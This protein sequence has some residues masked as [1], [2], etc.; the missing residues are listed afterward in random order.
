VL[1]RTRREFV[2]P[3]D[4][5]SVRPLVRV[6]I[7]GIPLV[8]LLGLDMPGR[9]D[10]ALA[11]L[12]AALTVRALFLWLRPYTDRAMHVPA[13]RRRAEG[14]VREHGSDSLAY[15]PLRPH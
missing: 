6:A 14:L 8:V 4:P 11:V 3:G 13:E 12:F 2:A 7:V 15:F 5:E 9:F 10:D 1:W